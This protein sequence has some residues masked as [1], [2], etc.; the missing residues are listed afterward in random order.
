MYARDYEDLDLAREDYAKLDANAS[1][2]LECSAPCAQSCP[3][4]IDIGRVN[5][6][7]HRQLA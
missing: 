6:A 5:R 7:T 2:C 1:P 4:G 3:A